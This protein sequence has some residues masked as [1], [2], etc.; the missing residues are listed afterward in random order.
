[1]VQEVPLELLQSFRKIFIPLSTLIVGVMSRKYAIASVLLWSTVASA[2]KLSLAY[3]T[4]LQ[5][6]FYASLTSLLLFAFVYGKRFSVRNAAP[7]VYLGAINPFLYYIV[8]FTAY[9]RLP[10]QEAQALNYTWPL[11]LVVFSVLFLKE[12]ILARTLGGLVMGFLGA[13]IVATRGNLLSLKFSDPLGV[14]L[15]LGSAFIWALYWTLNLK[16]KRPLVEKMFWNFFFGF[17]YI[18]AMIIATKSFVIPSPMPLLGAVYVGLFEMGVTFLLWYK[19]I[20]SDVSFAS[21]LAYLV[22]F[23]SLLFI[24]F[25][26]GEE[27]APTSIVGLILIVGGIIIGKK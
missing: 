7:S 15:G 14:L 12:R 18:S 11:V 10:A 22:P 1:M 6:L 2:F 16:D 27:I 26:V 20:E 4:P 13:S 25:L 23:L 24:H 17:I 8:L 3:F 9:S 19:A 21:N 5:L